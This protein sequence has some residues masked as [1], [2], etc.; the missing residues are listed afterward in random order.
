MHKPT[1]TLLLAALT[2]SSCANLRPQP[3]KPSPPAIDCS[4]RNRAERLPGAPESTDYRRWAAYAR[5]LLGVIEAEVSKRAEVADCL[6]EYR[7]AGT[8][9]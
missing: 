5:R 4:E 1:L 7:K 6:D 8:I 3:T 9:R 2:L